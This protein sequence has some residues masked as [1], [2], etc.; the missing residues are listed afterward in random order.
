MGTRIA[1]TSFA[2]PPRQQPSE[3]LAA[4]IGRSAEWILRQTGVRSRHVAG[5]LRDPAVLA[6][7]AVRPLM[8]D[9][10][11]PDCLI[12][13]GAIPRQMLP[14]LSVF[15]HRELNLSPIPS[16]SVN[17]SCMSFLTALT[18]ADS[19]IERGIYR[20]VLVCSAEL[21]SRGRNFAQPESAALLGDGAAA[22]LIEASDGPSC[23][24]KSSSETWSE[25]AEL[26]VVRGGGT[27]L[28]PDSLDVRADDHLFHMDGE[29]L[30]RMTVPRLK[31]FLDRFFAET[32]L[33]SETVRLIIPHQPSGPAMRMLER[34][35]FDSGCIVNIIPEYG[36]CVA[37]SIPMALAIA[38]RDGRLRRGE[39]FLMLGTAAGISLGA[40]LVRW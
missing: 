28:P 14:E 32:D 37:A 40:A 9:V 27:N 26:A 29:Q 11:R 13:A 35:G 20:R 12:Y 7:H 34:L 8:D 23:I 2:V 36:N 3:E 15:V 18:V 31:R 1:A 4:L 30:L 38:E 25:G 33:T 22:A 21:A 6:A 39:T 19:L 10:G 17:S 5:E 16:F 24:V